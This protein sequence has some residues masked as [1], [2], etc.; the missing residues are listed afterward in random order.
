MIRWD[1]ESS[2]LF[3]QRLD[4]SNGHKNLLEYATHFSEVISK[5]VLW[6]MED[7]I[8]ALAEL[9]R[10]AFPL[11][12]DEEAVGFLM[13]SKNLQIF[14]ED[15]EFLS[16]AF[17]SEKGRTRNEQESEEEERFGNVAVGYV[18]PGS[19]SFR[20]YCAEAL[21]PINNDIVT[22]KDDIATEEKPRREDSGE[23]VS[24]MNSNEGSSKP[25]RDWR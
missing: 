6:E 25:L 24:S 17:P 23:I 3:T 15:A 11:E 14:M 22:D 8:N 4:R 1:R 12:F 19:P 13:K 10:L 7:H 20:V 16:A 2:I 5:G 21:E 18:C 9:I